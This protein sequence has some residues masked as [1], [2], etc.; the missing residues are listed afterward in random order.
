M[1]R[2]DIEA[3]EKQSF[4]HGNDSEQLPTASSRRSLSKRI[5]TR[6]SI[7][8]LLFLTLCAASWTRLHL[9]P[10]TPQWT[11]CGS[12]PAEARER[13]CNFDILTFSWVLAP[14]DDRALTA[15][16]LLEA[17]WAWYAGFNSSTTVAPE[18]AH[19]RYMYL[20]MH[21]A[22]LEGRPLD[23]H[24]GSWEHT[25]H[26]KHVLEVRDVADSVV[27]TGATVKYP[28]CIVT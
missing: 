21:R 16:F 2:D 24:L 15:R 23:G 6:A 13:G 9:R 22:M 20:K 1:T 18:V 5:A 8:A 25:E 10:S 26:C 27:R 19:A 14:C 7:L 4:L 3:V 11:D 28:S 12:S 17:E